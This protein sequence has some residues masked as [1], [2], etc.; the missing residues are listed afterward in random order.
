MKCKLQQPIKDFILVIL[1]VTFM[2]SIIFIVPALLGMLLVYLEIG[3]DIFSS[4]AIF[5]SPY[6][7]YLA[8][9]AYWVLTFI[10]GVMVL[11]FG[12]KILQG[13]YLLI[14]NRRVIKNWFKENIYNCEG[15]E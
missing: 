5:D 14:F 12:I 1:V 6:N 11:V 7:F 13:I 2:F 3:L 8:L 10:L 4:N 9:G 15:K